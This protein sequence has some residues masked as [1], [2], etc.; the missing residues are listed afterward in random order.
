MSTT[1]T[2]STASTASRSSEP[3]MAGHGV[4]ICSGY[5]PLDGFANSAAC[6]AQVLAARGFTVACCAGADATRDGIVQAWQAVIDRAA[7]D[8]AIAIYYVGHGAI[9]T[10]RK[11][12]PG[13]DLP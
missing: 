1:S 8:D 10:N 3:I 6:I 7:G 11:Y 9:T 5:E 2:S 12:E 4:V 13:S